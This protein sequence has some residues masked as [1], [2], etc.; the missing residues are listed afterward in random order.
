MNRNRIA[1]G[2]IA[3]DLL[4]TALLYAR[5]P[6]EMPLHWGLSGA[7]DRFGARWEFALGGPLLLAFCWALLVAMTRIDPL[8]GRPLA[9]DAPPAERGAFAALNLALMAMM[10]IA[11]VGCMLHFSGLVSLHAWGRFLI[12]ALLMVMGNFLPRVR[13]NYFAGLRTPWTLSSETVWR[14]TNRL[15]GKLLFYGGLLTAALV[16]FVK[17]PEVGSWA[18]MAVCGISII[19]CYSASYLWWREEQRAAR[20]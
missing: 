16:L 2:I 13:P 19:A 18:L 8:G 4:A 11:H 7:P 15:G 14:R 6:L 9:A 10:G 1:L 3:A 5:L 20:S 12:P 17:T